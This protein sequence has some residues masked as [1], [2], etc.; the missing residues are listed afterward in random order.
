ME[1]EWGTTR[2]TGKDLGGTYK[3]RNWGQ[4]IMK[5]DYIGLQ[6]YRNKTYNFI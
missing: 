1:A 5:V 4:S 6:K 3:I 2:K